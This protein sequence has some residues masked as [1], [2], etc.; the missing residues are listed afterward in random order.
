MRH[1]AAAFCAAF[2]ALSGCGYIGDPLP[3]A[4]NIPVAVTDLRAAEFGDTM[5]LEFTL[6]ALTTE[7]LPLNQL[8]SVDIYVGPASA[9]FSTDAWAAAARR[10]ESTATLPG[11]VAQDIPVRDWIGKDVVIGVRAT[12]P[13][14]KASAWSNLVTLSVI[15]PLPAPQA[16]RVENVERGVAVSWQGTGPRFRVFRAEADG[17][18]QP[19]G[20]TER[21]E[22][23]DESTSYGTRYQYLV[24]ALASDTQQSQVAGPA[25][26]TP[27]D[28]FPPAVPSGVS[29][30]AGPESIELA[31]ERNTEPDFAGYVLYRSV[32]NS[33]FERVAGKIEAPTYSDTRIEPGKRYRY[34]VSAVD[35]SG[36]E[37]ARSA[38]VEANVP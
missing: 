37:S 8:R 13:R 9:P 36:N 10:Y 11:P 29:A 16:V 17:K 23:L 21:P 33:P 4:L 34:T 6:P 19:L 24:Q 5:A 12:G 3:P 27:E 32:D 18:P 2:V 7:G 1:W 22:Y 28:V 15:P 25:P 31:W 26:I 20:E 38:A 30:V 35:V 14:G